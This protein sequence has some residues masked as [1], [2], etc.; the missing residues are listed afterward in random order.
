MELPGRCL[1]GVLYQRCAHWHICFGGTWQEGTRNMMVMLLC[2][3]VLNCRLPDESRLD[4]QREECGPH[5]LIYIFDS[6]H[7]VLAVGQTYRGVAGTLLRKSLGRPKESVANT[8]EDMNHTLRGFS[9]LSFI[10]S[11][12]HRC[13]PTCPW[14]HRDDT[15]NHRD[16]ME[17]P[18]FP[19]RDTEYHSVITI[20][21]HH[22]TSFHH[23]RA[24]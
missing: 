21:W 3:E 15:T 22:E 1:L 5:P 20:P 4:L 17:I 12:S 23:H 9:I 18:W 6:S 7:S 24:D 16:A 2:C 14:V 8:Y 19:H 10:E 11:I 13:V